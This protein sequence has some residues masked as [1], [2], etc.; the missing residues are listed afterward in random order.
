MQIQHHIW[1]IFWTAADKAVYILYGLVYL[2]QASIMDPA[3]LGLFALFIAL[4]IWIFVLSD[5]F[6]LQLLI[7][8]GFDESNKKK[9]NSVV[10]LLHVIVVIGLSLMIYFASSLLSSEMTE[11]RVLEI[12][13]YLPLLGLLMI[14][15]TFSQKIMLKEHQTFQ[16]FISDVA[17]FAVMSYF[18]LYAKFN[19]LPWDFYDATN[20]Y[21]YGT[22]ASSL[23]SVAMVWRELKFNLTGQVTVKEMLRFSFPITLTN[24]LNTIPKQLDLFIVKFFFDL[25]YVGLYQ[26]AKT[27]FRFFEEG[28]NGVNGLV[29]P[30]AVRFMKS[31]DLASFKQLLVKSVSFAFLI[32]V[33]LTVLF[34]TGIVDIFI[35]WFLT[36]KYTLS[37]GLFKVML[38]TALLLPFSIFYFLVV[39]TG[40]I[41]AL[42][43]NTSIS[44]VISLSTYVV[45]GFLGIGLLMPL[46]Y[47]VYLASMTILNYRLLK[48][49]TY[50]E[51]KT[52]DLFQGIRD[53]KSFVQN[54]F[55]K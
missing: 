34:M 38:L 32:F 15:R 52:S 20:A 7:Q 36:E 28:M 2:V 31:N 33:S 23:V 27:L 39:A 11:S 41:N 50:V 26:T 24:L 17:F 49:S 18:I 10:I 37:L 4:N 42:L 21:F 30:A 43:K 40:K 8:F 1:K 53:I 14:P 54:R 12:G 19:G 22:A 9:V 25:H 51:C 45:V 46:G 35:A 16:I 47:L 29:Y 5:S 6:A 55:K 44:L 48:N 3:E 13:S